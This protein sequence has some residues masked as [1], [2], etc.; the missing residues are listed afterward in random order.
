MLV[1]SIIM[2]VLLCLVCPALN[3][4]DYEEVQQTPITKL[5]MKDQEIVV[6]RYVCRSVVFVCVGL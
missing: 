2:S 4:A 5:K 3:D 6:S 1:K